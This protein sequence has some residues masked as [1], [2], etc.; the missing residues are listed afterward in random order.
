MYLCEPGMHPGNNPLATLWLPTSSSTQEGWAAHAE[1]TGISGKHWPEQQMES[2]A[3]PKPK[4]LAVPVLSFK[5][6]RCPVVVS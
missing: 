1:A 3:H 2:T 4:A 5:F 6:Q